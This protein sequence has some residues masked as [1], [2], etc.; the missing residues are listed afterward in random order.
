MAKKYKVL[1]IYPY[2]TSFIEKD[3]NLLRE[4]FD[5]VPFQWKGKKNI[6]KLQK[7]ILRT[8]INISWFIEGHATSA[9]LLSKSLRKKSIVIA[10]GWDVVSMPDFGYGAMVGEKRRR[11]TRFAL[12]RATKIIAVSN[13]TKSWTQKWID[14]D[15]IRV[16]YHGFDH[17][18]FAPKGKK[19]NMVITVGN[20]KDD[21]TIRIKGLKSFFEVAKQMPDTKFI[22]IGN[23][24]NIIADKWNKDAPPNLEIKGF[25]P[26][27]ELVKFYQRAKVYAQLSY[28]ESFGCALAE[29]M[30]CGCTP[31]VTKRGGIPEVVGDSGFY[32]E[33]DD[34]KGIK[35]AIEKALEQKD[36]DE[37]RK[38]IISK[39]PLS[40]RKN[41]LTNIIY[42]CLS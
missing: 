8:D 12:K 10:G 16:V 19:E 3:L 17:Q 37:P 41:E 18:K 38:R 21:V 2:L 11:K 35:I 40:K 25:L 42:E 31:V 27:D 13:S 14:R 22:L 24:K 32:I 36:G 7:E 1:F 15:D 33:Y 4:E 23:H 6:L 29:A 30:L 28:Q 9:T 39:F 26:P 20:L 5:V 34:I